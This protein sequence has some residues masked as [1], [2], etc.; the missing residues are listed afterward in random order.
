M[1]TTNNFVSLTISWLNFLLT[2]WSLRYLLKLCSYTNFSTSR[3]GS[4]KLY[5]GVLDYLYIGAL[6]SLSCKLY[7]LEIMITFLRFI[8][9]LSLLLG[10]DPV[11]RW[12][13]SGS[14]VTTLWPTLLEVLMCVCVWTC[15]NMSGIPLAHV[16]WDPLREASAN[17]HSRM[18]I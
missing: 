6:A 9:F 5:T 2:I 4:V 14:F 11:C 17:Y 15:L 12:C 18:S 7:F 10:V 16:T 13:S 3:R 1:I 8:L